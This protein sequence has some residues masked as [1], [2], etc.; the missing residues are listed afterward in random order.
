MKLD[1]TRVLKDLYGK[2]LP[3]MDSNGQPTGEP[4]TIRTI[5]AQVLVS[6]VQGDSSDVAE[7]VE[8][9]MLATKIVQED[10]IELDSG[11]VTKIK[12]WVAARSAPMITG[13]ICMI[14]E[15]KL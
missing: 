11:Q 5:L 8:R 15:G 14:L 1:V 2:D 9:F 12:E 3:G 4:L 7:Q 10:E 13:Q 6:R